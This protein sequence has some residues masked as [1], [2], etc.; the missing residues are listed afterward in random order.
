MRQR[1]A[2][3][4]GCG[5]SPERA[6]INAGH[7]NRSAC[8]RGQEK[9]KREKVRVVVKQGA[10]RRQRGSAVATSSRRGPQRALI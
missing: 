9:S 6:T 10:N 2:A 3:Y 5:E 1:F 7:T 8:R 4:M